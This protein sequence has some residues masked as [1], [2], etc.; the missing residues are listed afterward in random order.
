MH[1]NFT[2]VY[3]KHIKQ[4]IDMKHALG[5]KFVAQQVILLKL[6]RFAVLHRQKTCTITKG[7]AA[8]WSK[9]RA[10]ESELYRYTRISVLA[11][12]SKY[13]CDIKIKSYIPKLPPYPGNTFIPYIYT[14]ADIE[15]IFKVSSDLQLNQAAMRSSIM[16]MPTIIRM[17]YATG[18]RINELLALKDE[19]VNIED[20][21]LKVK[22]SKNGKERIIPISKTLAEVCNQYRQYRNK[23]PLSKKASHFFITLNGKKCGYG[24]VTGWFKQCLQKAVIQCVGKSQPRIHDLRHTFAVTSLANMAADGIDLYASLPILSTYLGHQSI[25]ATNH[26]VRLTATMYPELIKEMNITTLNVFPKFNN[27]ETD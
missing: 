11:Q 13:L 8:L 3:S 25:G 15:A 4:F 17:L 9:K 6:D 2:S 24:G 19:D 21:Y 1:K 18:I 14:P 16:C 12:F 27:Y 26:Y 7:F 5:F 23:L 22:D 10:N 20:Q